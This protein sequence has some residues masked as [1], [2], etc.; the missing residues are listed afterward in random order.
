MYYACPI[1]FLMS[2]VIISI[3]RYGD[4]EDQY[5]TQSANPSTT[6]GGTARLSSRHRVSFD[7]SMQLGV[8][9][10]FETLEIKS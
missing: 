3:I 1:I 4:V 7:V 6:T 10:N 9:K 5:Q 8:S 2:H